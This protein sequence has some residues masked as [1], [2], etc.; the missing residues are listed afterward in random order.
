MTGISLSRRD[1][2]SGGLS[3]AG[4]SLAGLTTVNLAAC[5]PKGGDKAGSLADLTLRVATYRGNP[6]SFFG[7]AGIADP[8]YKLARTQFAGGNLIAEAINARALDFGG[9]S[10]IPP[11]FVAAQPGNQVRIVGVLKGDVNNQVL[12]VPKGSPARD[13]KDLKGKRI[14]YVKAT[15]SHYILLRLLQEAGL[16]WSDIQPVALSP[17]DGLAAFQSGALDAWVIYGVIVYQAREAGARVLRTA[18]G[19]LSGNYLITAAKEAL[20]D[21]LRLQAIGDYVSRYKKV[22][23]WINAD[24][25]RWARVR[26][27]ATGVKAAYYAQEFKE[28]SSPYIL[29]PISEAA[30]ASEQA[31]ADTFA[32]AK[33]IPGAVDVRPLWDDRL[34]SFLK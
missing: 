19:I 14:G 7:E 33:I 15:T 18:L 12:L 17:Q 5:S 1:L 6:E 26:E 23:D 3:I 34:S 24:G 20:D 16:S 4:L 31:V 28:R 30:I 2:M 11:I 10:E 29:E 9:M 8:P 27:Q 25:E 21:P 13:F 32:A 22:F